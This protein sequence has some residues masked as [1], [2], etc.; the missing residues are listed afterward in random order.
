MLKK[1]RKRL[2]LCGLGHHLRPVYIDWNRASAVL[3]PGHAMDTKQLTWANVD[4]NNPE[5][6]NRLR[7]EE[8]DRAEERI[9]EAVRRLRE[10]GVIDEHGRRVN[11]ELP[12]DMREGSDTDF[13][14]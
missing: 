7:E 12:A 6:L 3:K 10:L 8:L 13:G 9:H 2:C 1:A 5:E 11:R 4:Y 14:G